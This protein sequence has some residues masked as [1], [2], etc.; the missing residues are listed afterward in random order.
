[1]ARGIPTNSRV[2]D[3]TA[4]L[5]TSGMVGINP[6]KQTP[7]HRSRVAS[8]NTSKYECSYSA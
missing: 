4:H 8:T 5:I 6:N 1:M 7:D 2:K 3:L